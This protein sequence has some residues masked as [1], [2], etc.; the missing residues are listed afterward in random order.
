MQ[1][2]FF[3]FWKYLILW[4]S[5]LLWQ[6]PQ[7]PVTHRIRHHCLITWHFVECSKLFPWIA[8]YLHIFALSLWF[9]ASRGRK[10]PYTYQEIM[11]TR[12]VSATNLKFFVI[13][14]WRNNAYFVC[15]YGNCQMVKKLQN[16]WTH[17][18]Y[19]SNFDPEIALM[20]IN[21]FS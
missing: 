12:W 20:S 5:F 13:T 19:C 9:M 18:H 17:R 11:Q 15:T 16:S 4:E 14:I 8:A 21:L 1:E 10:N 3:F 7:I 6:W 2:W